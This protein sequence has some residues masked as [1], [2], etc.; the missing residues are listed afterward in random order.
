MVGYYAEN[1]YRV[2]MPNEN[3]II[4]SR[5][6]DFI[7]QDNLEAQPDN[8]STN[9]M[10]ILDV[11]TGLKNVANNNNILEGGHVSNGQSEDIEENSIGDEEINVED[12]KYFP[13]IRSSSRSLNPPN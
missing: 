9:H 8:D 13:G 1:W 7:E 4:T 11:G 5:D 6:V 10:E 2:F 3:K 12:L